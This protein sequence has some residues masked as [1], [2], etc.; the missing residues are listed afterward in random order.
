MARR[1]IE[2]LLNEEEAASRLGNTVRTLRRWRSSGY[3][4]RITVVG[5]TILYTPAAI[6]DFLASAERSVELPRSRGRRVA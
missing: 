3:G 5:R 4:P 1:N 6:A 2:G